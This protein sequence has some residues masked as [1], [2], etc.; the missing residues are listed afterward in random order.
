M[1]SQTKML[2]FFRDYSRCLKST[3][4][5]YNCRSHLKA[6]SRVMKTDTVHIYE[7]CTSI[8][9]NVVGKIFTWQSSSRYQDAF[10]SL[11]SA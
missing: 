2:F 11:A 8:A 10:A 7:L 3:K 1:Q 5:I 6:L 9:K 4:T